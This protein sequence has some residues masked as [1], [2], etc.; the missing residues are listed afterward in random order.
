MIKLF[1]I[2]Y[3]ILDKDVFHCGQRDAVAQNSEF[4]DIL[5]NFTQHLLKNCN[6]VLGEMVG[7]FCAN[8]SGHFDVGHILGEHS[9]DGFNITDVVLHNHEVVSSAC[10]NNPH[11]LLQ[12]CLWGA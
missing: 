1:L 8:F 6:F 7:E 5:L 12:N 10:D 9:G 3:F 4:L 11:V 2:D